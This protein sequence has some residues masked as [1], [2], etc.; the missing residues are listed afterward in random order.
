VDVG[1]PDTSAWPRLGRDNL[2]NAALV[3]ATPIP[4]LCAAWVLFHWFPADAIPRAPTDSSGSASVAAWLLHHPLW[5]LNLFY[6]VFVNLQFW[7]VALVQRSSWLIDPYWTLIPLFIVGFYAA[8]PLATPDTT[9]L[10]LAA[11]AL[12]LWSVR[13]TGNYFRREGWR[14]GLREDWRYARMRRERPGFWWEQFFVVYLAQHGMLVG[15]T[16]PFWAI[17]FRSTPLSA[18]DFAC[19]ALALSG[20]AI[21]HVADGQLDRFMRANEARRQRRQEVVRV[22]DTGIWRWSRHPNYFGEQLFW[23]SIAG[24]GFVCGEPWVVVGTVFNSLVLVGVTIMTERRIL[25]VPERREAYAAYR[26]R[27]SAWI[28]WPPRPGRRRIR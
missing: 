13:L 15:L 17:C 25:D 8:N 7:A 20:I 16:L 23:W 24:Y 12:G 1:L 5:A 14:F 19:F 6:F 27:T 11:T 4:A 9:R 3:L 22:L 21:A 18:W 26:T 28:P 2:R 10:G